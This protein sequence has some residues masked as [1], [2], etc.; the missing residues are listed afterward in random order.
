[1]GSFICAEVPNRHRCRKTIKTSLN[2]SRCF[3]EFEVVMDLTE[4][5]DGKES[6]TV[7]AEPLVREV[8]CPLLVNPTVLQLEPTLLVLAFIR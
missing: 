3:G 6:L 5:N 8:C 1:M 7:G 4:I 2:W